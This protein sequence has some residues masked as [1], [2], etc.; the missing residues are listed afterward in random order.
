M[1][2]DIFIALWVFILSIAVIILLIAYFRKCDLSFGEHMA[3]P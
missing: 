3:A 2:L 1:N